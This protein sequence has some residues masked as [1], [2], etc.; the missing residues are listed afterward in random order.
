MDIKRKIIVPALAGAVYAVLTMLLAPIS[1]GPVQFRVSEVLCI[2]P[3]FLPGTAW[4]LFLGCALSNTISTAGVLDIIFGSAATLL[5][6]LSTA[7]VGRS[8]RRASAEP[9]REAG[10]AMPGLWTRVKACLMPVFWNGAVVGAVLAYAYT[11]GTFWAGFAVIG[12]QVAL[13]EAAVMLAL[14]LPLMSF[15]LRSARFMELFHNNR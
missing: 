11:P 4:G 1:Y 10:G 12:A 8:W 15:L 5:A 3:F 9:V 13:G 7:A 2:L 6:G 14:G